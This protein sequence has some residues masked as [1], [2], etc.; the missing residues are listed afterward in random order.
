MERYVWYNGRT[1]RD[2]GITDYRGRL[3]LTDLR[4]TSRGCLADPSK[5]RECD[6]ETIVAIQYFIERNK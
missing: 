6:Q 5:C 3:L 1:Y 2:D 4:D